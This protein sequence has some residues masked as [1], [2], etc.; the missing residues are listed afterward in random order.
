MSEVPN[1]VSC[2]ND[3]DNEKKER[4]DELSSYKDDYIEVNQSGLTINK[5]YFPLFTSKTIPIEKIKTINIFELNAFNGKY[6]LFGFSLNFNYF[7]YD[8]KRSNKTHGI[9]I[10]EEGNIISIA[11]T[12]DDPKKCYNVL[13]Y[14]MSNVR[15]GKEFD[16]LLKGNEIHLLKE[17]KE[18]LC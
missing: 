8:P 1:K 9:L 12:P 5:Y 2:D 14:L 6:R 3:N 11:I 16:P 10:E 18:K 7:H 17:Q 13:K 4:N 15:K